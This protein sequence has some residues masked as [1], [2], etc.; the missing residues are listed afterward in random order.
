MP[1]E[2]INYSDE[3]IQSLKRENALLVKDNSRLDCEC[4]SLKMVLAS[5]HVNELFKSKKKEEDKVCESEKVEESKSIWKKYLFK[6]GKE[7]ELAV[8][9]KDG[10]LVFRNSIFEEQFDNKDDWDKCTNKYEKCSLK[11]ILE[12]WWDENAPDELKEKYSI[13]LPEAY[14][15]LPDNMLPDDLKGKNEHWDIFK[16]WRNRIFGHHEEEHSTWI[17]TKTPHPSYACDVRSIDASGVLH[18]SIANSSHGVVPACVPIESK[19]K[20]K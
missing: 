16:D 8:A 7:Y 13:T 5:Q 19:A 18:V 15:I 10:V 9:N 17:W 6:N 14:N 11:G 2:K 4:K 20:S 1:K 3:L 12:K